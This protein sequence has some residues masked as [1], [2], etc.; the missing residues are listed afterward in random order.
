MEIKHTTAFL[1]GSKLSKVPQIGDT[2]VGINH[3]TAS[4]QRPVLD[5]CWWPPHLRK[6]Y[7]GIMGEKG[8]VDTV[9]S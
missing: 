7:N 2:V 1:H 3:F 5:S 8:V 4:G 9:R 6:G